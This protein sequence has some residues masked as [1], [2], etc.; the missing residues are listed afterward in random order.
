M[1]YRCHLCASA[2]MRLFSRPDAK[3]RQN[4]SL[5]LCRTCSLVQ[6]STLP[7]EALLH[8]YYSRNYRQDYKLSVEP[9]PGRVHRAGRVALE[10]LSRML[11]YKEASHQ[12]LFDVGAGGGELVYLAHRMGMSARGLEPHEGYSEFARQNYGVE[13]ETGGIAQMQPA[14]ADVVTLFHV[15]E[16]LPDPKE[17]IATLH[18]SLNPGGLL[19]MEVPNILQFDASPSNIYFG[20]HL[21]YFNRH[22]LLALTSSHFEPLS[23]CDG[24]NLWMVLRRRDHV[25]S[26]KW[27]DSL[28]VAEAIDRFDQKG[29]WAYLTRGRGWHKP[30]K[31]LRQYQD[32]RTVSGLKPKEILDRLSI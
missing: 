31:R 10:R 13:I 25:V 11:P 27:P 16:H 22:V 12:R 18:R 7:D 29:W 24:G 6:Q 26:A 8:E 3:N 17:A 21:F 19:V 23:I 30:W 5:A 14:C 32:E 4:L 20:A 28:V 2:E 15:L 1:M 9:T